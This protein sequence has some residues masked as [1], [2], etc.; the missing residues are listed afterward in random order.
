M[1][2]CRECLKVKG[3]WGLGGSKNIKIIYMKV[4]C[5]TVIFLKKRKY[6][7]LPLKM[8]PEL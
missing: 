3:G 8:A 7:K 6:A 4:F 2:R 1:L 5:S